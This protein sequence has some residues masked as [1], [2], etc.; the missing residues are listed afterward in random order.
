MLD[1][2]RCF[3]H[4]MRT[5]LE[6]DLACIGCLG[7]LTDA[8]VLVPCG[9][10]VC[11]NCLTTMEEAALA[12]SR[13][14]QCPLCRE[15]DRFG[16]EDPDDFRPTDNHPNPMLEALLARLRVKVQD[17]ET[18][19]NTVNGIFRHSSRSGSQAGSRPGSPEPHAHAGGGGG[20]PALHDDEAHGEDAEPAEAEPEVEVLEPEAARDEGGGA[21]A[22]PAAAAA[23]AAEQ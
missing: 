5:H 10:S 4:E 8:Q 23:A 2:I 17:V 7:P 21:E 14:K 9:H 13:P 11:R 16:V 6:V 12:E 18:L 19:L 3:L 22:E 20:Q 15:R 1:E